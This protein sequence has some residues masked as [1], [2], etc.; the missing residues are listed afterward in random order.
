MRNTI[1]LL[2]VFTLIACGNSAVIKDD[3][4][5]QIWQVMTIYDNDGMTIKSYSLSVDTTLV[6]SLPM[7]V[8]TIV[9]RYSMFLPDYFTELRENGLIILDVG[10][11]K[12][13][14]LTLARALG[15]FATL[16]EAQETL[17]KNWNGEEIVLKDYKDLPFPADLRV[18]KQKK[19]YFFT[20]CPMTEGAIMTNWNKTDEFEIDANG[21]II[22]K[23]Q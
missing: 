14:K 21:K 4:T 16:Q 6:K 15:D 18:N 5:Y 17:L 10:T 20:R 12:N 8:R 11:W 1:I 9:A 2:S 22:Y 23:T 13:D 7:S 3:K 19:S